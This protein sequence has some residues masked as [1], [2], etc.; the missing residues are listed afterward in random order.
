MITIQKVWDAIH[1]YYKTR[2]NFGGK[3]ISVMTM[4]SGSFNDLVMDGNIDMWI[5]RRPT[6]VTKDTISEC[7][8][9]I[10]VF[11]DPQMEDGQIHFVFKMTELRTLKI[12]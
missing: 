10:T 3:K 6:H 12:G 5:G 8:G 9:N 2:E 7:F 11:E 1:S 4:S